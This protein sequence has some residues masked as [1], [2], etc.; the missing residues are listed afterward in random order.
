MDESGLVRARS[1][2]GPSNPF[3]VGFGA[4]FASVRDSAY[5][6]LTDAQLNKRDVAALCAGL[7]GTGQPA[8][9]EKM[10]ALLATEFPG[11]TVR[12]CTDQELV[13]AAVRTGP[14]IVLVAGTGSF[15]IG[16]SAD[17]EIARAGGH[18]PMI[19]D[20]GS[21]YDIGRRAVTTALKEFD[22][23]GI[24]SPLGQRILREMG[25]AKWPEL[26]KRIQAAPD[27]VFPRLF[28][29]TAALA[30]SGDQAAQGILRTAAYSLAALATSLAERVHVSENP[31][32]LVKTGGMIGRC[33]YF[34]AHLEER[35]RVTLPHGRPA[36][37]EM[38][39]AEAA[40]CLAL[41]SLRTTGTA[42]K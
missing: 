32:A 25:S 2:S 41:D 9:A 33:K 15:A 26:R 14:A 18:G 39:P 22:R 21:A 31:F 11:T 42:K 1:Q 34:D 3:R 10:R 38:P 19:S 13:L 37:L 40:A 12:I 17:G 5:Q 36:T 16:R 23:T 28:S 8:D 4:A 27:E 7:A 35:L 6:A 29:V 30:D 20:E 24:D